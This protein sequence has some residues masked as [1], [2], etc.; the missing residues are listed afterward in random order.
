M[1]VPNHLTEQI[2]ED[3]QKLY[4]SANILV[5]TK[6]DFKKENRQQLFAKIATGDF[7]AVII[8]HSQLGMIPLSKERQQT[9]LHEQIDDIIAGIN[10]MKK[11]EGSK[12]QVKQMERTKKSLEAKLDK[13]EKSHDD[14]L[15]F[16]EMGID[17]LVVDEL[18]EFKN[19]PTP[20]KL[21]NVAGIS[22]S[23]SQKA[24]DLFM[25]VRYL[26]EKTGG[27]GFIGATGTPISNS[28]TELHTMMRFLE[29]DFLKDHGL[30]NFDNWVTVITP[31]KGQQFYD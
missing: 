24:L 26:D 31:P 25:K 10:E 17:K 7:D 30:A 23:A 11:S 18:H 1:A 14:F 16:E 2:G 27:K 21:S 20:T 19:V 22:T 29:Y 8:G 13:L 9:I 5:A 28:V 6:N 12:F 15:T 4:P 3:F